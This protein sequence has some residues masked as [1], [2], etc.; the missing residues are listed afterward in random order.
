MDGV[1]L[2]NSII[3]GAGHET[4]DRIREARDEPFAKFAREMYIFADHKLDLGVLCYMRYG[5]KTIFWV[6]AS[7]MQN[8]CFCEYKRA[9]VIYCVQVID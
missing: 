8:I 2:A 5:S 7:Q 9:N 3:T 1:N 4:R 6:W